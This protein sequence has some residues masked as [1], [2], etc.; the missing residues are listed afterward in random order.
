MGWDGEIATSQFGQGEKYK[1]H[2][3]LE[4]NFLKK[5]TKK[6][7]FSAPYKQE[8]KK[9]TISKS[10]VIYLNNLTSQSH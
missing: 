10:P 3:I 2:W 8:T 1:F 5:K 4:A 7:I 9:K 6:T